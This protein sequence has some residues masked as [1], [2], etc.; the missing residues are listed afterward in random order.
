MENIWKNLDIV[1]PYKKGKKQINKKKW[2]YIDIV[3]SIDTN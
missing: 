1:Q 3:Y 2:T